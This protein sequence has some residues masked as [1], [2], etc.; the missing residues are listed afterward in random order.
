MKAGDWIRNLRETGSLKPSEVERI[1]RTIADRKG[2]HEYYLSRATLADLEEKGSVP[3]IYKLFSLAACLGISYQEVLLRFGVDVQEI[4]R[5]LPPSEASSTEFSPPELSELHACANLIGQF[6]Q[7]ET[8]LLE[9]GGSSH[10]QCLRPCANGE[11]TYGSATQQ[12][13]GQTTPWEI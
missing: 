6:N 13:A 7:P 2:N 5:F 11:T 12:L 9:P 8:I 1:S 10:P 3:S 4:G